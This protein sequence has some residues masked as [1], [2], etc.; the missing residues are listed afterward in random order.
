MEGSKTLFCCSKFSWAR[1]IFSSKFI[2]N[3]G[4]RPQKSSPALV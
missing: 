3:L 2:D 1:E 4:S